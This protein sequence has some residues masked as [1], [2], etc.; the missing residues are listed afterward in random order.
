MSVGA[1]SPARLR[2]AALAYEA[3]IDNILNDAALAA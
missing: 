2:R 1:M 3:A